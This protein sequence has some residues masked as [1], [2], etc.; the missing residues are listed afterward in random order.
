[1]RPAAASRRVDSKVSNTVNPALLSSIVTDKKELFFLYF[2]KEKKYMKRIN[3]LKNFM[4]A[5]RLNDKFES[6]SI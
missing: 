3:F 2:G 6:F 5:A 4:F 1:V